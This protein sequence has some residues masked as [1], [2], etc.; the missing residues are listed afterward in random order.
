MCANGEM[1]V[2]VIGRLWA[3]YEAAN[4]LNV[5][6]KTIYRHIQDQTLRAVKVGPRLLRIPHSELLAFLHAKVSKRI[7]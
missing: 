2:E 4:L 6:T 5:T 3:V 7:G 1:D